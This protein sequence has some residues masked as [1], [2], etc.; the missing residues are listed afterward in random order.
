MITGF[1]LHK[2]I[3][4][5]F[6][7]GASLLEF[8]PKNISPEYSV[9]PAPMYPRAADRFGNRKICQKTHTCGR[10]A[11]HERPFVCRCQS[12][13]S[14]LPQTHEFKSQFMNTSTLILGLC[15]SLADVSLSAL[16]FISLEFKLQ[17][18]KLILPLAQIQA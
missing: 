12:A 13:Q 9:P 4:I 8:K 14:Y 10:G 7:V 18:R 6:R 2:I 11:V 17:V 15:L 16:L 5:L 3:Y 1:H